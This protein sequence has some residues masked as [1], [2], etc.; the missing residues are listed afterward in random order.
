VQQYILP[1][2]EFLRIIAAQTNNVDFWDTGMRNQN[3]SHLVV[4]QVG[5]S[6]KTIRGGEPF[7]LSLPEV[8]STWT[9]ADS[10]QA[11]LLLTQT[12]I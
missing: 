6:L 2:P 3:A 10:V 5:A 7:V 11:T 1:S 4:T 9:R 8:K 12:E